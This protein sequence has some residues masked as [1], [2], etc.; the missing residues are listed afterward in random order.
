MVY[1]TINLG[2]T[3]GQS[4][5]VDLFAAISAI[6]VARAKLR[7]TAPHGRDYPNG[8][9]DQAI[10]EHHNRMKRLADVH[11]ELKLQTL[12]ICGQPDSRKR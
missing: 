8:D 6:D 4:L 2:G 11:S 7:D 9:I 10:A 1:P 12:N 5:M 3:T